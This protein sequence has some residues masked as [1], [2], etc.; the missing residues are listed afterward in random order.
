VDIDGGINLAD[1]VIS[2]SALPFGQQ[3]THPDRLVFMHIFY[4]TKLASSLSWV[5][6]RVKSKDWSLRRRGLRER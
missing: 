3:L 1:K 4:A 2:S 6:L 5:S